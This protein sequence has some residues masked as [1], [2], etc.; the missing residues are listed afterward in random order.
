MVTDALLGR[1]NSERGRKAFTPMRAELGVGFD[2]AKPGSKMRDKLILWCSITRR[3]ALA[4]MNIGDRRAFRPSVFSRTPT[5]R[6]SLK[7]IPE[8]PDDAFGYQVEAHRKFPPTFKFVDRRVRRGDQ[9][10]PFVAPH[11]SVAG[12]EM[13]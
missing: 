3:A 9:F 12:D 4:L 11:G 5:F 1:A 13:T 10:T 8:R 6:D 2:N 7:H